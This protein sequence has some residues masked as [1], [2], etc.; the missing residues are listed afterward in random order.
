MAFANYTHRYHIDGLAVSVRSTSQ[1]DGLIRAVFR[2]RVAAPDGRSAEGDVLAFYP[3]QAGNV[4]ARKF[5]KE[6]Q[7]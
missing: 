6:G 5:L 3:F 2:C 4:A 1:D 7:L